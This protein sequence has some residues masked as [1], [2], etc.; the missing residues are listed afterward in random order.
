MGIKDS[1]ICNMCENTNDSN[2][3]MLIYCE[4]SRKLWSDVERWI[5]QIGVQNYTSTENNMFFYQ[6]KIIKKMFFFIKNY[7]LSNVRVL[8]YELIIYI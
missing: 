3:H 8:S 4:K 1:P 5:N 7:R 2:A 6:K